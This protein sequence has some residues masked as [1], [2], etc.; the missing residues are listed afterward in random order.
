MKQLI[1][2]KSSSGERNSSLSRFHMRRAAE[3]EVEILLIEP[4]GYILPL[5][6]HKNYNNGTMECG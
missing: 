4:V 6:V 5:N 3:S 2:H 1:D